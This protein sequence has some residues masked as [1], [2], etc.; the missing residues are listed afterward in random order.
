MIDFIAGLSF[1]TRFDAIAR[2]VLD[3][4]DITYFFAMMALWLYLTQVMLQRN[5]AK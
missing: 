5:K 3:L 4:R 2:G 1:L